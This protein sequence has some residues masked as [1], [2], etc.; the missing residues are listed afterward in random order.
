MESSDPPSAGIYLL[1]LAILLLASMF[2]SASETAFLSASRLHIRYLTEKKNRAALRVERIL[3]RKELFLNTILVGNNAVNITM[4]AIVTALAISA[5]GDAGVGVATAA[6]TFIILVFGEILP[7]SVA[8]LQSERV[9]L[10]LS[11]PLK[12]LIV[13]LSPVVLAFSLVTTI[14]CSAIGGKKMRERD[15]VTEEDLKAL[16][17]VGEEEGVLETKERD[18]LHKILN[19]ADLNTR[20][21][22]T[23]RTDIVAVHIDDTKDDILK[24]ARA[25]RFSRYPVFGDDIDDIRGILYIKDLLF[26]DAGSPEF[27][28]RQ[29]LRPALFIFESR[30]ISEVQKT[31]RAENQNLA[32]VIDE[33]GGISGL[34]ST[35][36]LVEEIFGA[37]RDEYDGIS[38]PGGP[39]T[40]GA[41]DEGSEPFVID[42]TERL[43]TL[44]ARI[45]TSF[46][47]SFY[48]TIGGF[49]MEKLGDIPAVGSTV[50]EQ[51]LSLSVT[52]MD[53]NRIVTIRVER[54][55]ERE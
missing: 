8:L 1:I 47:S 23:P 28:V 33:Y 19:Y 7:K 15:R 12:F 52:G 31:L 16:I 55:G 24:L 30:K 20:D 43:D 17:E 21:I 10:K 53:G 35:E 36:D 41:K 6:A 44:N 18:M 13:I 34:V 29:Y 49:I 42:G 54:E 51:G 50:V 48:D 14:L 9:A 37:I 2:F 46:E 38:M 11:L 32:V 5:F 27:S 26:S 45:G 39:E 4:S 25:S 40:T 22:M 3:R